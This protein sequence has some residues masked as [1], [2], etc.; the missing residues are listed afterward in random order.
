MGAPRTGTSVTAGAPRTDA[1]STAGASSADAAA[2][3]AASRC[4]DAARRARV[5]TVRSRPWHAGASHARTRQRHASARIPS[6]GRGG[7]AGD[8]GRR[9]DTLK[10]GIS[11]ACGQARTAH[12]A[13]ASDDRTC[14]D[15]RPAA[16]RI[17]S[18]RSHVLR[19]RVAKADE[20]ISLIESRRGEKR[21]RPGTDA[22]IGDKKRNHSEKRVKTTAGQRGCQ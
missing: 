18:A 19:N 16:V 12:P 1:S 14:N 20:Q 6:C 8:V 13:Q 7:A 10:S 2:D 21:A 9:Q 3:A 22:Q 17:G 15:G 4:G 5:R 11:A